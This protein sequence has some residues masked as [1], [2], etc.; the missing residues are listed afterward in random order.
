MSREN[1]VYEGKRT[2][3]CIVA[4]LMY[5]I[6]V[7]LFVVPAQLYSGGLMGIC[8][9]IRTLLVEYLHMN[10]HSFDIA[11]II[12]YIINVPI[13]IIA[14]TRMGRKF[15]AKTLV[16][17]TAMTVFLS[18]VPI[19]Q[20]VDDTV[21]AC[22]V[23]GIVSGAGIGIILRMASSGGGLDVV[24]VLLT[25]WRR[26]F[27][28]GKVYLIVNLSLYIIC[29]FLFDIEIVVYSVIFASVHS[30]A[31]DK[32]H[33]QNIN[34]E[35]N[36][37]TKLNNV[38]LEKAIM[39]EIGRGLTKWTTLGAYTYEQ[40]HMLYITLSKYEVS[41]LKAVVHKYDPNAFIVINEG[42]TIDGNFLKKL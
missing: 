31:I 5:A 1:M 38:D 19:V 30:L 11:G 7:N 6:G 39:E 14:F 34:V 23:G 42:V 41:R 3:A 2:L 27:S 26:D 25:K 8:Q 12:Y 16:T 33:I 32:V 21:A 35:A 29:L 15:F 4:S 37:I 22:V 18:V 24:G 9:V 40:S 13:F 36:I 10:F 28:V 20:V 17:V